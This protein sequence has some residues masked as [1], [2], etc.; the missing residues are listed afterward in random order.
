[1]NARRFTHEIFRPDAHPAVVLI[2]LAVAFT[3]LVAGT[4]KVLDLERAGENF[5]SIGFP[6]A[7]AAATM[8]GTFEVLCGVLVL[9]GLATRAAALPL[10]VIIFVAL[11]S[12][13]LPILV[14]GPVGP[15]SGPSGN[16]GLMA[17]LNQSRL[18]LTMLLATTFL[19]LVGAGR[20]SLDARV[21]PRLALRGHQLRDTRTQAIR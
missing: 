4:R 12:T 21:W 19:F 9:V 13:K 15:F 16:T 8:V 1:M 3:F 6:A 11:I 18:D 5:A 14:G 2:R 17:F 10:M 20:I 7:Q